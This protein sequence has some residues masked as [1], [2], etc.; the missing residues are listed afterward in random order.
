MTGKNSFSAHASITDSLA[1]LY[2]M[3]KSA[4]LE[5]FKMSFD[6]LLDELDQDPEIMVAS[7]NFMLSLLEPE[8][9]TATEKKT[10]EI[11]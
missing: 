1:I 8:V 11:R 6:E 5:T 3:L 9:E 7:N 2:C 10:V 4:N